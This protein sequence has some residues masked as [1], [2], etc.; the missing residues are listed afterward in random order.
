MNSL[1]PARIALVVCS[2]A[3]FLG[4]CGA[5]SVLYF[6]PDPDASVA[7]LEG[8]TRQFVLYSERAEIVGVDR[9]AAAGIG[10]AVLL[11]TTRAQ[12]PPGNRCVQVDIRK[13]TAG[14]CGD[15]T[16]CAFNDYFIS[17]QQVQL[18]AG[19]LKLDKPLATDEIVNGTMQVEVSAK[20]FATVKQQIVVSC[21]NAL[22]GVCERGTPELPRQPL[23]V[24][25]R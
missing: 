16:I 18:Q 19:S 6:S 20:G 9:S 13:C 21:G 7:V 15:P 10:R 3:L 11:G 5:G 24:K 23:P 8:Y 22:R 1:P 17:G 14:S 2:L 25:A 4:G 12:L